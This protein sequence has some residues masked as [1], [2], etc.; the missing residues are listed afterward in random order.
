M[1]MTN[2]IIIIAIII[3]IIITFRSFRVRRFTKFFGP[4]VYAEVSKVDAGR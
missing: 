4:N 3:I 2:N 1:M